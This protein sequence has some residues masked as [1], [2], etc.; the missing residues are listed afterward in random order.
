MLESDGVNKSHNSVT[1]TLRERTEPLDALPCIAPRR[2]AMPHY[3]LHR[4]AC[5]AIMQTVGSGGSVHTLV[6]ATTPQR[7]GAAP[8]GADV[9]GHAELMLNHVGI[10]PD[11]LIRIAG[12][13]VTLEELRGIA[14]LIGTGG[15]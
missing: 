15:P 8:A 13:L 12:K 6:K 10:W 3:R 1:F 7:G 14:H 2:D 9:I 4:G 5:A 11:G